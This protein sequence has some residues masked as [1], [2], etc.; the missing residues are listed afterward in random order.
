MSCLRNEQVQLRFDFFV[1]SVFLGR[2]APSVDHSGEELDDNTTCF[3]TL[4]SEQDARTADRKKRNPVGQTSLKYSFQIFRLTVGLIQIVS[5]LRSFEPMVMP[6]L[7]WRTYALSLSSSYLHLGTNRDHRYDRD[8]LWTNLFCR[9]T[10][11]LVTCWR[12]DRA[13]I[14]LFS[15][16]WSKFNRFGPRKS[17]YSEEWSFLSLSIS[18][19]RFFSPSLKLARSLSGSSCTPQCPLSHH[20]WEMFSSIRLEKRQTSTFSAFSQVK[21]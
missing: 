6:S 3:S 5:P 14:L 13:W 8:I 9:D 2:L 4:I 7:R 21:T 18:L 12:S 10:V 15:Q 19:F 20:T 11:V 17:K 16:I 1:Y